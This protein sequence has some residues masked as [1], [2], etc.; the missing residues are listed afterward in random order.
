[1]FSTTIYCKYCHQR[2]FDII[3][4]ASG[5]IE[6]KCSRCRRIMRVMLMNPQKHKDYLAK[7]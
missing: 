3:P 7:E 4:G 2:L 1:M 5:S 6:I